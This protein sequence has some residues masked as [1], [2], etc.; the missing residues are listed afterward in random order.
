MLPMHNVGRS[1][2]DAVLN[3]V[4]LGMNSSTKHLDILWVFG[5]RM[6]RNSGSSHEFM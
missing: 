6:S 1:M 3:S 5:R 4:S 2:D